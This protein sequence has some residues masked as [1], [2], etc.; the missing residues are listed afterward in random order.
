[1]RS[2][3][4]V[5]QSLKKAAG[6]SPSEVSTRAAPR[7]RAP[8][9]ELMYTCKIVAQ[10][11]ARMLEEERAKVR[12]HNFQPGPHVPGHLNAIFLSHVTIYMGSQP[13]VC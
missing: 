13:T 10:E 3:K 7:T 1:M 5:V 6:A 9:S 8:H 12:N 4:A 11:A 2:I